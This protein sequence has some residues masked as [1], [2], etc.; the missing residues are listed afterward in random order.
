ME[1]PFFINQWHMNSL[2][3][4]QPVREQR[5][6]A[7]TTRLSQLKITLLQKGRGERSSVNGFI[8][9][10]AMVPGLRRWDKASVLGD[11][12][13]YIKQL[14]EKVNVL[15]EQTRAKNMESVVF[16][17]KS[18]LI[19][20]GDKYTSSNESNSNGSFEETLPEIEARFCDNNVLIRVHCEKEKEWWR[21]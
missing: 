11:S 3:E 9:L 1:D 10:S 14:Q 6:S 16:V 4:A 21:K 2:D 7:Q 15:E 5:G 19:E 18:Q 12:I 17:R 8:A 13:K 20:N